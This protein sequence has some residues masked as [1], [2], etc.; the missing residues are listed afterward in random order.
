MRSVAR[1]HIS[2]TDYSIGGSG[3][4]ARQYS[5]HHLLNKH[6]AERTAKHVEISVFLR[7]LSLCRHKAIHKYSTEE[8]EREKKCIFW[9]KRIRQKVTHVR[10]KCYT[11]SLYDENETGKIST[12]TAIALIMFPFL[13][14][15]STNLY[16]WRRRYRRWLRRHRD[17][18]RRSCVCVLT[19]RQCSCVK[20]WIY[21][22]IFF[23]FGF[24]C[25][26]QTTIGIIYRRTNANSTGR[27]CRDERVKRLN[28]WTSEKKTTTEWCCVV[29]L[30]V[31]GTEFSVDVT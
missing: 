7:W 16:C 6:P 10:L 13:P 31:A 20:S 15:N 30:A 21:V 1:T 27:R 28:V 2:P 24:S 23:I 14:S 17:Y 8:K 4:A 25:K 18:C 29:L 5:C 11:N 19:R 3:D 22:F 26:L 9:W 12:A